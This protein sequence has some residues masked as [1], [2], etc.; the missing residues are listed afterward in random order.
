MSVTALAR[1]NPDPERVA[2]REAIAVAAKARQAVSATEAAIERAKGLVQTNK[3]KFEA[4]TAAIV[5]ARDEDARQLAVAISAG[6]ASA[7]RAVKKARVDADEAADDLETAKIAVATLKVDLEDVQVEA[8]RA[9]KA[10][11]AAAAAV[12]APIATRMT[13]EAGAYRARYLAR[14]YAIN[15][16]VESGLGKFEHLRFDISDA[17]DRQLRASVKQL[18]ET[19]LKALRENADAELP[20]LA[21]D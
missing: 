13:E 19:A 4:A 18:W 11:A 3:A 2:L 20:D 12:L 15:A 7:A 10:V 8:T 1:K 17:E 6:G 9:G 14:M 21:G 5:T 16:L